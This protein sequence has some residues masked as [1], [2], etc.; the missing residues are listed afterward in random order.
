M[1]SKFD[2]PI[3]SKPYLK[4][5]YQFFYLGKIRFWHSFEL[6]LSEMTFWRNFP[7]FSFCL[8]FLFH[9]PQ[10]LGPLSQGFHHLGINDYSSIIRSFISRVSS[11]GHQWATPTEYWPIFRVIPLYASLL[12]GPIGFK[13]LAQI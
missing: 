9:S 8:I 2:F 1:D 12:W 5:I 11:S 10:L 13:F 7:F 4:I 6:K 3:F